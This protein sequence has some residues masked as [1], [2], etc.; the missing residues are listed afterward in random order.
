MIE[1]N[2]LLIYIVLAL[3]AAVW[4]MIMFYFEATALRKV[5]IDQQETID[6][7]RQTIIDAH[8]EMRKIINEN[9]QLLGHAANVIRETI[10]SHEIHTNGN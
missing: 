3:I 8:V 1:D 5:I 4:F 7:Q 9:E 10:Q 2:I 6:T